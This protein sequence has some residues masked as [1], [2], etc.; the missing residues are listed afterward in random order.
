MN[1]TDSD[2][3]AAEAAVNNGSSNSTNAT[4]MIKVKVEKE[5]KRCI[6][7]AQGGEGGSGRGDAITP[8]V[9]QECISRNAGFFVRSRFGGQMLRPRTLDFIIDTRDKMSD[10][11]EQVS[12]EEER[13]AI[14]S[15]FDTM[16]EWIYEDGQG[17]EA[18]ATT[19]RSAS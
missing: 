19:R 1:A 9:V 8:S 5:R 16:E 11:V 17:L 14:R 15:K 3:S 18:S 2:E 13:E 12:T 4:A 10:G 7:S 6:T